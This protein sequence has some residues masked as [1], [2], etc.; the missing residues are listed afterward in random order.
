MSQQEAKLP[1]RRHSRFM[2]FPHCILALA[3]LASEV[4]A[5]PVDAV[6]A[7]HAAT[8]WK[9]EAKH[10]LHH[11]MDKPVKQVSSYP[12]FHVVELEPEGFIVVP[13]EDTLPPVIAFSEN[14]K[15]EPDENN[16]LWTLVSSDLKQRR[17]HLKLNQAKFEAF[18][19]ASDADRPSDRLLEQ[20]A[21][22]QS[23]FGRLEQRGKER[24]VSRAVPPTL[25]SYASAPG[26]NSVDTGPILVGAPNLAPVKITSV[27]LVNGKIQ[28]MHDA[29]ESVSLS[30]SHDSGKT[31]QL[32]DSGV[33]WPV[34][35]SRHPAGENVGF[36]KAER[37]GLFD[38]WAVQSFRHPA[39]SPPLLDEMQ[40]ASPPLAY[41]SASISDVRVSPLISSRWSQTAALGQNCYNY[42]TPKNYPCG[43]V[44][45]AMSQLMRYWRCPSSGIGQV[46]KTVYIDG[47]Q[48]TRTTRGGN[49]LGGAYDWN[50]M[51]LQ[52]GSA[53]YNLAQWQ[54]IGSL[55][56]DA[57]VCVYMSYTYGASGAGINSAA[58]AL[59][60]NFKYS[61]SRCMWIN[62][63]AN[64][65]I[66]DNILRSNLAGG[67][68]VL[69]GISSARGGHCVVCDGFGYS[70]STLYYHINMG[71]A[72]YCD[73]WYLLPTVNDGV[74]NFD[75]V[76]SFAF[77]V[78]PTGTG[79]LI[80][81][82]VLNTAGAPVGGATV[83]ATAAATYTTTTDSQGYYGVIVAGNQTYTVTA[84]KSGYIA[85]SIGGIHVGNSVPDYN[86]NS[87][88]GNYFGAD[89]VLPQFSFS[90]VALI[91]SVWLR[92]TTPTNCGMA[93]NTV[94]IRHRTDRYP[95]NSSDGTAIYS[96]TAQVFEH[97]GCDGS[98]TVTN[99]YAIW[100]NNGSPY[101]SLTGATQ[102]SGCAAPGN[103]KLYWTSAAAGRAA[104]WFL[105]MD[106]SV[107]SSGFAGTY[108]SG[109]VLVGAGD[110]NRDGTPDLI[111]H[112]A[113]LGK[114]AYWLMSPDGVM[115]SGGYIGDITAGWVLK[116]VGDID[117][118]GTA[119]LVWHNATQGK[120]A[121]WLL[122][123]DGTKRTTGYIGTVTAGWSLVAGGDLDGDGTMDL[124]WQNTAVG[125][126]A[127]WFLN[128]DGSMRSNGY[129][130]N[131][132]TGWNLVGTGDI[133]RDGTPDLVW[134]NPTSGRV[135]YW[136]L[137]AN[138]TQ[139][140]SG[141]VGNV[142]AG[143]TLVGTGDIDGD[144]STDLIWQNA[145]L[146][147]TAFWFLNPDGT[148]R[149]SGYSG[150]I[151]SAW[152]LSTSSGF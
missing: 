25:S 9:N 42:Y 117:R 14:G 109:W 76:D 143:W 147:K 102:A 1:A 52:P 56:Y 66:W 122:N 148:Q 94:Y 116:G 10:I 78:Y 115:L 151:S 58:T 53:S 12:D 15:F 89:L 54:M 79:E 44:A 98:G 19:A 33:V 8:G 136:I 38:A 129:V 60:S 80:G 137:N 114:A 108:A 82:R 86:G 107:C 99:Y 5:E 101:A 85:A 75:T 40:T 21:T 73:A 48:T 32:L 20:M 128:P 103:L 34:W 142:T 83:S 23:H 67:Y 144:K 16:P 31:W 146:G 81:G 30:V 47:S 111:W 61:Q 96:G 118:D 134:L 130:G 29:D 71:W 55:C 150:T 112:N 13:A 123:P 7:K 113:T 26:T 124:L 87:P 43:C 39:P 11:R 57:G 126:V 46:T 50:S 125:K 27:E 63:G 2:G 100:G 135:A 133:N 36:Y 88:N 106:G 139:R 104:I 64:S 22:R 121:Y 127:Y 141:Y 74:Y 45:T 51:P 68:P 132:T 97:T 77:N 120:A 90:A 41:Q 110:I 18:R 92:W 17:A 119:D 59:V 6:R 24:S 3:L 37:D 84:S 91:N 95:T 140:S 69:L 93:N 138:G 149:S 65:T 70:G 131:I 145:T 35:T 105:R 4:L 28:I 72:G 152:T 49:G 62:S